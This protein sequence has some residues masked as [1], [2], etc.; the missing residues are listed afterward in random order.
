MEELLS[1]GIQNTWSDG[2]EGRYLVRH[3]RHPVN[4]FG[5]PQGG[6]PAPECDNLFEKA[7]P[8][9]FPYGVGGLE[10]NQPTPLGFVDHVRTMSPP[11]SSVRSLPVRR[12]KN[13]EPDAWH[14]RKDGSR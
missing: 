12:I 3:G 2:Q 13:R 14:A 10:A 5:R 4:D 6:G 11:K 1:W 8:T 9:L 7:F